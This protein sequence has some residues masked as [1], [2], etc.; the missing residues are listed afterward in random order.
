MTD[1]DN[2]LQD[3][4]E[5]K[6]E[7]CKG[8]KPVEHIKKVTPRVCATC[9]YGTIEDGAFECLRENGYSCDA[10]DMEQWFHVCERYQKFRDAMILRSKS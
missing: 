4:L 8:M 7:R 1:W 9:A 10:G 2:I 6:R 3:I 5:K